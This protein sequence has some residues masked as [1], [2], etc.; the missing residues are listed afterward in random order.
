[1]TYAVDK[2]EGLTAQEFAHLGDGALAY[3]KAINSEDVKRLF[4]QAPALRP[5]VR[6]FALLGADGSP[7][8]LTDSRDAAIANAWEHELQTVSLH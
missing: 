5:G 1:M 3:V 2:A 8:M 7:I 4:P 6:L